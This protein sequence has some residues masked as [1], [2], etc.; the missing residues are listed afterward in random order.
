MYVHMYMYTR[1][2][3]YSYIYSGYDRFY[4][5]FVKGI[6]Q[7]TRLFSKLLFYRNTYLTCL[8]IFQPPEVKTTRIDSATGINT[9]G[10]Q[11][12]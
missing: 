11:G 7:Q 4:L 6:D 5:L 10:I 3:T 12:F 9:F 8:A 1:T 2:N